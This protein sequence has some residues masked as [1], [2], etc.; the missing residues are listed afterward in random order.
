MSLVCKK[1]RKLLSNVCICLKSNKNE[2]WSLA[3][4]PEHS[5]SSLASSAGT[6]LD[7]EGSYRELSES[8]LRSNVESYRI[9]HETKF[10]MDFFKYC[11]YQ[12]VKKLKVSILLCLRFKFL[13]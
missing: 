11:R 2:D 1:C 4:I 10:L 6:I 8:D 3:P 5:E 7:T 13:L 9:G 12:E